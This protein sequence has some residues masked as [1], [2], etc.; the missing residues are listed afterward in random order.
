MESHRFSHVLVCDMELAQT[1]ECGDRNK[2]IHHNVGG[3]MACGDQTM[4]I[5]YGHFVL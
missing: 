2:Q 4:Q 5:I 1:I 3:P